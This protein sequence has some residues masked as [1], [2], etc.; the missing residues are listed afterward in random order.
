M[1]SS[2]L[3]YK[4]LQVRPCRLMV[5]RCEAPIAV[6]IRR[7]RIDSLLLTGH[8][9]AWRTNRRLSRTGRS[10]ISR[11]G[12]IRSGLHGVAARAMDTM[13]GGSPPQVSQWLPDETVYSLLC[14]AHR[15]R[16]AG[17]FRAT[18]A[19]AFGEVR[20]AAVHD[21]PGHLHVLSDGDRGGFG[22]ARAV[23]WDHTILPYY[24][25]WQTGDVR[26]RVLQSCVTA[27]AAS[28]KA[29]LGLLS[30]R[31]GASHPLKACP[32]CMEE[33]IARHGVAYWHRGHQ[34][35]GL[36]ICLRHGTA[37]RALT[38][39]WNG[40][41]RFGAFLP[42]DSNL[43]AERRDLPCRT[44]AALA[45]MAECTRGFLRF[46]E[47]AGL[48]TD[49][50]RR[51]YR[52]AL[53]RGGLLKG[54]GTV[55]EDGFAAVI[56]RTL[57]DL[58]W[59]RDFA[60]LT[61]DPSG[62]A[63]RFLPLVCGN[64]PSRHPLKH[65]ILIAALFD[66]WPE[67]QRSY[68]GC[69]TMPPEPA[70]AAMRRPTH[71]DSACE[72]KQALRQLL[73]ES[74]VSL[75]DAARRLGV[76][77]VT[78]QAWAASLG[79]PTPTRPKILTQQKR[80][81]MV[82]A[83]ERGEDKARVAAQMHLSV[84]TVTRILRTEVGLHARWTEARRSRNRNDARQAWERAAQRDDRPSQKVLRTKN[85]AIYAWLYRND[86][87]WLMAFSKRLERPVP[88]N[89]GRVNWSERDESLYRQLTAYMARQR[90]AGLAAERSLTMARLGVAIPLLKTCLSHLD[91]LPLTK[92]A[93]RSSRR[94]RP[95]R[96][97]RG[98][99]GAVP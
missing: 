29:R 33:D 58:A 99:A 40:I 75:T 9:Q 66:S 61:E 71:A 89:P 39:R 31:L 69:R 79:I 20:L 68:V 56:S 36:W 10:G 65:L 85:P 81:Q 95:A 60:R 74:A 64:R 84:G 25:A 11:I 15:I 50:A 87:Q 32:R 48:S 23:A 72:K 77:T 62:V 59:I 76:S 24:L 78:A 8:D 38:K 70:A 28:V 83:L 93:I 42:D 55:A 47:P 7:R 80:S 17:S 88:S 12:G 21:L 63:A 51:A 22:D 4:N 41:D 54:R 18:C 37:L 46:A 30:S 91:R 44:T 97:A 3:P 43:E 34:W 16:N 26:A 14:R 13:S 94:H 1:S 96:P 67:F 2:E 5:L 92:A 98:P 53:Q 73:C 49:V 19:V 57:D 35:P 45:K 27:S 52:L 90:Q 6:T 86:R 82:K